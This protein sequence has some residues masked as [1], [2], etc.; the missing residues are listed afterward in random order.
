MLPFGSKD[1]GARLL[2]RTRTVSYLGKIV[3]R[4][5]CTFC[6]SI[7]RGFCKTLRRKATTIERILNRLQG[8][9]AEGHPA[10]PVLLTANPLPPQLQYIAKRTHS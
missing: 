9:V 4:L 2:N 8:R 3:I 10:K 1:V 6:P 7:W 5:G